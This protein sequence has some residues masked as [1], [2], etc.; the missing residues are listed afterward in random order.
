VR[1]YD[2]RGARHR[3]AAASTRSP[4]SAISS[5]SSSTAASAG[6]ARASAASAA[7]HLDARRFDPVRRGR[8]DG[9]SA[10]GHSSLDRGGLRAGTRAAPRGERGRRLAHRG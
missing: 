7:A 10:A 8:C 4:G 9:R 6:T 5:P 3:E 2:A 1:S